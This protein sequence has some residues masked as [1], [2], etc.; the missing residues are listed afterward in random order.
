MPTT[1]STGAANATRRGRLLGAIRRLGP[2]E[3]GLILGLLIAAGGI[4]LFVALAGEM[5]EG[6]LDD[7]D[8]YLL[9]L[10]RSEGDPSDP[11]G[12]EWLEEVMRDL[13]A[14][15]SVVVLVGAT[16]AVVG[17]LALAGKYRAAMFVVIAIGSGM[18]LSF[19]IKHGFERPRP[20]LVPHAA[21]VFTAS[22][23]SAHSTM[24]AT[25]FLTLGALLAR[26]Q[27]ERRLR[28]YVVLLALLLTIGVGVS[29]VYLG[30]HWPSDVLAGW[31]LGGS[32]A[33]LCWVVFLWLQRRGDVETSD[34][35]E[36]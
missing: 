36:G 21:R 24:S 8:R 3:L 7:L 19:A 4:W 1:A 27:A 15:G 25:A 10:F 11:L 22:F 28:V 30:V 32:W 23:P 13:T 6:D 34:E 12:P 35:G 14:L 16:L 26:V 18:T 5:V 31:A 2:A 33:L 20:D 29:R 9:L 17:Y